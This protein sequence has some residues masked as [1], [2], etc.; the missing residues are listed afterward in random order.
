MKFLCKI[1]ELL[2]I[3]LLISWECEKVCFCVILVIVGGWIMIYP[4]FPI[5]REICRIARAFQFWLKRKMEVFIN[6]FNVL[7]YCVRWGSFW[8]GAIWLVLR[9]VHHFISVGILSKKLR[10]LSS[11]LVNKQIVKRKNYRFMNKSNY[12]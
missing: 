3:K 10:R 6:C 11:L 7:L 9:R 8:R 1:N 4:S 12:C 2:N 5:K